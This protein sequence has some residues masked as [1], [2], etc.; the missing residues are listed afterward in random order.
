MFGTLKITK[1]KIQGRSRP[2]PTTPQI[3]GQARGGE[4]AA[5]RSINAVAREG[6]LMSQKTFATLSC[7]EAHLCSTVMHQQSVLRLPADQSPLWENFQLAS[8]GC[9]NDGLCLLTA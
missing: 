6:F 7:H 1:Q 9:Q 5:G 3:T 4:M 2:Q 8:R